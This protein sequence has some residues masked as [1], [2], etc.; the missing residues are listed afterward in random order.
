MRATHA[1]HGPWPVRHDAGDARP[2]SEA[3]T[4]PAEVVEMTVRSVLTV[5]GALLI[6]PLVVMMAASVAL[7]LT[8]PAIGLVWA[9]DQLRPAFA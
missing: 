5:L 2:L 7:F 6:L 9:V 3:L 4:R 1:L 8:G